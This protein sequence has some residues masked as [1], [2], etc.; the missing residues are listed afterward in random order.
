MIDNDAYHDRNSQIG[1]VGGGI[2]VNKGCRVVVVNTLIARNTINDTPITDDCYGT[3]EGYGRNLLG[4]LTSCTFTGNG[5]PSRGLI[6][7]NTLG[8]LQDN[9]GPN[10][11]HALLAGSQAIDATYSSGCTDNLGATLTTDQRVARRGTGVHCDIGA[12]EY[13]AQAPFVATLDVDGSR[14]ATRYDA[15]TDGLLVIRYIA[16]RTD[17]V[18]LTVNALDGTATRTD[19]AA[20]KAYLDAIRAA[21]DI[22]GNGG[23]DA[24]TDG[25]LVIRYLL[26]SGA[27]LIQSAIGAAATRTT[28]PQIESY[29]ATL[30]P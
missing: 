25:L 17:G 9:G 29:M 14:T 11:T 6:S 13:G 10:L 28:A 2:Y 7:P 18:S 27:P 8:Q 19:P 26:T 15:L 1:G 21:L 23:V 16:L 5:I 4:D 20:V 24:L 22:D 3:L 12:F 30:T